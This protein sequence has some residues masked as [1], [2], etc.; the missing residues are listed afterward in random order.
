QH[1][2]AP[3]VDLQRQ[4]SPLHF[5]NREVIAACLHGLDHLDPL[6]SPFCSVMRAMRKA[7][8]GLD[9]LQIQ[10]RTRTVDKLLVTFVNRCSAQEQEIATEF[11]LKHR[12]PVGKTDALLLLVGERKAQARR[13][14]PALAELAQSPDGVLLMQSCRH[15]VDRGKITARDKA[16]VL[17]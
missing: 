2:S 5:E 12:V 8:D 15:T 14:D 10:R 3:V 17:L 16:V 4:I 7:E 9:L 11:Q 6:A 1:A 13:V